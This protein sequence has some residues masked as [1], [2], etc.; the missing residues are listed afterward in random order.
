MKFLLVFFFFHVMNEVDL[1][2][3][4]SWMLGKCFCAQTGSPIDIGHLTADLFLS[5]I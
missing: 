3:F 5:L 4:S 1:E 2:L